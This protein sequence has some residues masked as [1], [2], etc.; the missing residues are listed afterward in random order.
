MSEQIV[1]NLDSKYEVINSNFNINILKK[2][3]RHIA[4]FSLHL[5]HWS[6]ID[7][8]IWFEEKKEG[9]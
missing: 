8:S 5:R 7:S 1:K 6:Y 2:K 3:E 9:E 4:N